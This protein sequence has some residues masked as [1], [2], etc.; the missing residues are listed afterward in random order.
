MPGLD[1]FL[2]FL[3][4]ATLLVVTPGPDTLFIASRSL[5]QGPGAGFTALAGISVG[6]VVHST[7]AALGLAGLFVIAPSLYEV[8]RWV[9]I[10]YLLWLAWGSLKPAAATAEGAPDIRRDNLAT[11]FRQAMMTNLLNPKVILFFGAFL[12][13][14]TDP[15]KGPFGLQLF[16]LGMVIIIINSAWMIGVIYLAGTAGQWIARRPRLRQVQRW[17]LG[18]TLGAVAVWLA[19]PDGRPARP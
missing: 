7:A 15:A 3:V 9:G 12:P 4:A 18:G 13:Q 8:V 16:L 14:F 5:A 1:L 19:W 10:A 11:V 2:P 6:A 17:V